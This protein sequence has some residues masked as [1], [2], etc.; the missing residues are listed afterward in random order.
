MPADMIQS[1]RID[2]ADLPSEAVIFGSSAAMREVYRQTERI[3]YNDLPVLI[4]GE[5]GTGKEVVARFL[6]ARSDR[7]DFPF[8]KVICSA[9]PG[10]L[11]EGELFGCG[12][13]AAGAVER[14]LVEAAAGGTLFFDE[15][16]DL[17]WDLQIRLLDLLEDRQPLVGEARSRARVICSTNRDLQA[18]VERRV[19][20]QDLF[21]RIDVINLSLSPLRERSEDIPQLCE[22]FIG[23]L[24]KKFD[25]TAPKLAA[26]AIERLK[27]WHWPGNL[28]E[29]ENRIAELVVQGDR[30]VLTGALDVELNRPAE[31]MRPRVAGAAGRRV[32]LPARSA[33]LRVLK[34]NHWNRR[35]AAEDLHMSY[36]SFLARMRQA[37][38]P[39][40]RRIHPAVPPE[41]RP[42][43][44]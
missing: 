37:G 28:R 9:A 34:A 5:R 35:R 24:A 26:G 14:G 19:F 20:R 12:K 16:G 10:G 11:T 23:K 7:R 41:A 40:R 1:L 32:A 38:V 15:I 25:R 27:Q 8:V 6:H 30:P 18:A 44:D 2:V 4:Q 31:T 43:C 22:H 42:E 21:Y 33:L 17:S 3:L 39:R 13:G 29:L 36:R